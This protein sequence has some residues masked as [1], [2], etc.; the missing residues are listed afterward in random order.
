LI[1]VEIIIGEFDF[2]CIDDIG[3]GVLACGMCPMPMTS[4]FNS[5]DMFP[6]SPWNYE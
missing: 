5:K 4:S 3:W 1:L 6:P 2:N